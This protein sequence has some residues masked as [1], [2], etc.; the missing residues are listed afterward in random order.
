MKQTRSGYLPKHIM[1]MEDNE[2]NEEYS[3]YRESL[4]NDN[5]TRFEVCRKIL[6]K[7]E[8]DRKRRHHKVS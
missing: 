8:F 3:T 1:R 7:E 5:V 2:D 6:P 4:G